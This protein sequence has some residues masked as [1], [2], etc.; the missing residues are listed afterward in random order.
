MKLP[1]IVDAF[2][3]LLESTRS[4]PCTKPSKS[5]WTGRC[6]PIA[7]STP[8]QFPTLVQHIAHTLSENQAHIAHTLSENQAR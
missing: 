5:E 1:T 4:C 7:P 2:G 3:Y 8:I 6:Q